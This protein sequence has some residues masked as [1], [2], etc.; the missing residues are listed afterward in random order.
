MNKK[1]ITLYCGCLVFLSY[2]PIMK[3]EKFDPRDAAV[4][5][6]QSTAIIKESK[7]LV[8]DFKNLPDDIKQLAKDIDAANKLSEKEKGPKFG[9]ILLTA[10]NK[11]IAISELAIGSIK[12]DQFGRLQRN[13]QG[14]LDITGKLAFQVL[15]LIPP[16]ATK[17]QEKKITATRKLG[18]MLD[19][20]D[21][22]KF[23]GEQIALALGYKKPEAGKPAE[24]IPPQISIP[25]QEKVEVSLED[26]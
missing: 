9:E 26:L 24:I 18:E 22:T 7:Q 8:N 1:V 11:L 25:A 14:G 3:S 10:L 5:V 19:K 4:F 15:D 17:L 16:S 21:L 12:K 6:Q 2:N 20:I 23:T 13:A